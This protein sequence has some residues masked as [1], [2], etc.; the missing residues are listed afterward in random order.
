MSSSQVDT[1]TRSLSVLLAED[2]I[3]HQ[4]LALKLL[5]NQGHCVTLATNGNEVLQFLKDQR[6]DVVLMDIE[7]PELDGLA[8][9]Q[10]IRET[11][12]SGCERLP[13]VAVTS[14]DNRDECIEAGMDAFLSKPLN[15]HVL[16]R[17]LRRVIRDSVA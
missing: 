14:N 13:I 11:E 1:S 9:T 15:S 4:R 6:F 5:L 3:F 12:V 10:I 8:T 16:E 7:M 2:S 17:T